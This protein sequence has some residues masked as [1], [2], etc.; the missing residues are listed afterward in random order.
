MALL[1][2][3]PIL[4]SNFGTDGVEPLAAEPGEDADP[5]FGEL[6]LSQGVEQYIG[7]SGEGDNMGYS[8]EKAD[9]N[10]DGRDD[11][12]L[13][14]PCY[15]EYRGAVFVF[16]GGSKDR[17]MDLEQ[18][19]IIIEHDEIEA[20]FGLKIKTG[21]VN[22]DGYTDIVVSGY[23][24]GEY[25][26]PEE[27]KRTSRVFLFLGSSEWP[28]EMTTADADSVFLGS[29]PKHSFGWGLEVGDID[30]DDFDDILITD[31]ER[32]ESGESSATGKTYEFFSQ[33]DAALGKDCQVHIGQ[34]TTNQGTYTYLMTNYGTTTYGYIEYDLSEIK[35]KIEVLDATL[36]FYH[37]YNTNSGKI[38]LRIVEEYWEEMR[39]T[40]NTQAKVSKDQVALQT[41]NPPSNWMDFKDERINRMIEGWVNG[42]I[43]N[44]GFRISG[45]NGEFNNAYF[46]S[47]DNSAN[48]PKIWFTYRQ[49]ASGGLNGT[50][51]M[52][53]G[54]QT[55]E[56]V[57]NVS[58]GL[59]PLGYDRIITNKVNS[60]GFAQSDLDL[61]DVNGDGYLDILIG[62]GGMQMEGEGSGAVQVV[63]GGDN[64]PTDIDLDI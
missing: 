22:N 50:V 30:R 44:Y 14:A 12:I 16:M 25:A 40:W 23:Q 51:Y 9:L 54:G 59:S 55:L 26:P 24:D 2:I 52:F 58:M 15:N 10:N 62:S 6:Q 36:S 21:D 61:G 32:W 33:P 31:M 46:L 64:M 60:T 56:P 41:L 63:F 3:S 11:V 35:P 27:I 53:E 13:G 57:R 18:A 20:Y 42:D 28:P 7:G 45:E 37:Q 43:P 48:Q 4:G 19:D 17:I 5:F 34:P 38:E 47:S 49:K 1:M 39:M 29:S 8:F